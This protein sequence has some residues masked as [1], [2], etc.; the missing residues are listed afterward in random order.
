[1][2]SQYRNVTGFPECSLVSNKKFRWNKSDPRTGFDFKVWRES[3]VD[4]SCSTDITCKMACPGVWKPNPREG[5]KGKCYDYEVLKSICV[6]VAFYIDS[7]D[8]EER[9]GFNGGCYPNGEIAEYE[10]ASSG[11]TYRFEK[12]PIEVRLSDSPFT[13]SNDAQPD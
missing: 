6:T 5:G 13:E 9:M 12:V 8:S 4:V 1:M 2:L 10:R 11:T 7:D 3:V